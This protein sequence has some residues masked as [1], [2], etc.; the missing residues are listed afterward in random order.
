[1]GLAKLS[2]VAGGIGQNSFG[3][4][5]DRSN[6]LL[7]QCGLVRIPLEKGG[8]GQTCYLCRVGLGKLVA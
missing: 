1:M 8:V 5:W 7:K 3:K 4:G 6:L 2:V